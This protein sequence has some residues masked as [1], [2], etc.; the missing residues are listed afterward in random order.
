VDQSPWLDQAASAEEQGGHEVLS[1][2]DL[3]VRFRTSDGVVHAVDR[4]SYDVSAGEVV[5]LVGESGSGKSVSAAA[6]LQL[7]PRR[8]TEISG[9]ILFEGRDLLRLRETEMRAIRGRQIAMIFQEPMTSLNPVLSIATQV[10][11]PLQVHQ[12]LEARAARQLAAELLDQVGISD[13]E[14]RLDQLP[15]QL[16]GGMRQRVMIAM[17]ISCDPRI[18]IADEPTTALDATIAAQI[19]DLLHDLVRRRGI[20]LILITHNLGIVARYAD[21]V[22]VVYAGRIAERASA[23]HLFTAPRHFYTLALLRSLPRLDEGRAAELPAIEGLPPDPCSLARGC[24]FAPRCGARLAA[25]DEPEEPIVAKGGSACVRSE[26]VPRPVSRS[27]PAVRTSV[28]SDRQPVLVIEDLKKHFELAGRGG[29][30]TMR[31]VDGIGLTIAA[32]ATLGLVGESGSGKTTVGRLILGL[33]QPTAGRIVLAGSDTTRRHR[34]DFRALRSKAQMVFQDS[35]SA[36]DP[37]MTI[38]QF[39]AEPLIAHRTVGSRRAARSRVADLLAQVGLQPLLAERYP[40]ELSGGQRQ[41]AGIAR[42]LALEPGLIVCDEPVSAVDASVQALVINLLKALQLRYGVALLFISHD[43]ALVRHIAD[44]VAVM[45]LGRIVE[46]A[47]SEA[48]YGRPTHPYT[49]A[50]LDAVRL[51]DPARERARRPSR[52]AGEVPSPFDPPGGC[53]FRTRCA[54][55]TE[56]CA[57]EVPALR[58]IAP[59]HRVACHNL[60]AWAP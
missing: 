55:A 31:A 5:A 49:R 36:L 15:H 20:G 23:Q 33:E 32:G 22:N 42:A 57:R 27:V 45:Y 11:E 9:Q 16:S 26:V 25:C 21:R 54:I 39:I 34:R 56:R 43:L 51:P 12:G 28:A 59:E 17:A 19:L 4:I 44:D 35:T 46:M 60:E 37:R 8:R 58:E 2:N 6:I 13:P 7:L 14:R 10:M 41:R 40:R 48:L 30:A 24:R 38:G 3:V 1:V 47:P 50:L 29:R 18:V 52:L 53:G